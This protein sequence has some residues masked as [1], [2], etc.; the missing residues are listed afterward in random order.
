MSRELK[1]VAAAPG[2]AIARIVHFH[3]DFDFIPSRRLEGDEEVQPE[4]RRLEDAID[5][6]SR[7]ILFLRH[8]L[9][10]T[11]SDHDAKI[12]D[13]ELS[14]LH[15]K[16]FKG[17][18]VREIE[19]SRSNAETALQTVI[20]RYEQVFERMEDAVMRER[21]ADIRDVGR[22]LLTALLARERS[23]FTA[24]GQDF[25]FAA[26]E[27]LP[28][29]AG[30][31]DRR[32]LRG[33]VTA[34][35]G[36]Y[37]HGAILARSLGIPSV[38]GVEAVLVKA[39]T[40]DLVVVDGDS[41]SV[42]LR[43]G[44]EELQRAQQMVAER[45][46]VEQ[47][48][49]DL[50]QADAITSDGAVVQLYVNVEGVR[51]LDHLRENVVAGIGLFRTEF[52]FMERL[53]FPNEEEQ[54]RMYRT[55]VEAAGP[56]RTTTFRTLD[57]GGDKPLRYFRT[58]EE[59]NPVLGWRG[60]RIS[61]GWPDIFF[62]QVRAILRAAAGARARIL[63][64]MVTTVEEVQR[65]VATVR[66]VQKDLA[67]AS[68]PHAEDAE[69]GV[70]IEIPALVEIL[71]AVLPLV[72]FVSVGSNDLVQYMLAVDRDNPRVA[73][74]YD[75]CHPGVLRVL[76]RIAE[77]ANAGGKPASICG[78]IA[79][80]HY[81]TPLLLGMGFRELSMA[82]VFLPRV[83]LMVRTF[84][85]DECRALVDRALAAGSAAEVRRLAREECR[86]RFARFLD[87]DRAPG[88]PGGRD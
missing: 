8:E 71:P 50:R 29:D 57:I 25:V 53:K 67:D 6:A 59:R 68:E 4:I 46:A 66:Q 64:P 32:H 13:V 44:P 61:L 73:E 15:D 33:I 39:K 7:S 40:G 31:L 54:L 48:L 74:M 34:R 45:Q 36:K 51:E 18:L 65:A 77:A 42:L 12:Y 5:S 55:A 23:V 62:T 79:G 56:S 82:P 88:A 14:L 30:I 52:A 83:K 87:A 72:D 80:D 49:D 43:P 35:G 16:T 1:G 21:A 69:I 26:D 38:A 58:P 11:L 41:G 28:T 75:P 17:D 86:R 10:T 3:T 20:A 78:E 60:L 27:F 70:M 2:I 85:I 37:S 76:A 9:S 63:F 84:S 22:Q 19:A 81:Y 24:K 47:R